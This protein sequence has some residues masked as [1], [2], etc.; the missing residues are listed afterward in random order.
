MRICFVYKEDYPWDVRVEKIVRTLAAA[1][2]EVTLLARNDKRL[3]EREDAD[4]F[5]I[6]R[7]PALPRWCGRLNGIFGLPH[8]LNPV[9][10]AAL[11]R[12]LRAT[13][14]EVV[15]V[16]DLPL[17]PAALLMARGTGCKVVFDMAEAYPMMYRS[18]LEYS[19]RPAVDWTLKNPGFTGLVEKWSVA[20]ADRVLVMIEESR[21]RLLAQGADPQK[22]RIVSNTPARTTAPPREH[23]TAEPV[24]LLYV[25]FVTR[26]R[27]LG[28]L[29]R[30]LRAYLDRGEDLPEIRVDVV[31]KGDAKTEYEALARRLGVDPYVHFHGWC[32]QEFVDE[33]YAACDVG[34]LTYH[35]CDHWNHT[36]PNKLFDYMRSGMPVLATDVK[37]I[38]RIVEEVGCGVVFPDG[39]AAA[40]GDAL[41]RLADPEFRTELGGR[42]YAAVRDRYNWER[43]A[44]VMLESIEEFGR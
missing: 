18:I 19:S 36:I 22:V 17:M 24:R 1:G 41:A 28:N 44:A 37:P 27:G 21:D 34:V 16:R 11:R 25:G 38:K 5:R 35:V 15:V 20:R 4:G 29:L 39:N 10:L 6:R 32:A 31:G 33:L 7:L 2:H 13:R 42:G 40:C 43:D 14:A 9:W 30:G 26:I 12:T 3:P 23:T 8:F